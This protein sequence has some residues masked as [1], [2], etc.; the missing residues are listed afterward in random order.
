[1]ADH[2]ETSLTE[3]SDEPLPG[4]SGGEG[5]QHTP[6]EE[7]L[8]ELIAALNERFGTD[9]GEADRIWFEQQQQ[10]LAEDA[11][12]QAAAIGNDLV[13]FATYVKPKMDAAI[14]NRHDANDTLLRAYFDKPEFQEL[15][16]EAVIK[17][18]YQQ[19]RQASA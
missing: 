18:L 10:T 1:M 17:A 7:T 9:L 6:V 14:I 11:D 3:G 16:V 2:T 19:L 5:K 4:I 12:I 15:M 8:S 13:Q